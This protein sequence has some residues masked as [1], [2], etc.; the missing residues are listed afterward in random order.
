MYLVNYEINHIPFDTIV[1]ADSYLE[2]ANLAKNGILQ[3]AKGR[4]WR[5][6]NI[7]EVDLDAEHYLEY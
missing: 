5:I 3:E 4:Q 7:E 6:V 1:L 2:A